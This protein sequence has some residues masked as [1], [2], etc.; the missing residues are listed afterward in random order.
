MIV[1]LTFVGANHKITIDD[2]RRGGVNQI[3]NGDIVLLRTDWT[4]KMYGKWPDYFTQ[5]PFFP[6][7]SAE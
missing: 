3:K 1:D 5:S 6:P 7:E 4:D 2:L